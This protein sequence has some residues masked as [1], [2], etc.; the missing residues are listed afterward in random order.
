MAELKKGD[1]VRVKPDSELR[2]GQDGMVVEPSDGISVGLV[3][4]WDRNGQGPSKTGIVMT[5]LTEEWF[6]DELDMS[7]AIH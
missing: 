2:A 4:G 6:L 3:F 7:S 1:F 5:G